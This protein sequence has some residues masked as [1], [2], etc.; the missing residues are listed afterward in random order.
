MIIIIFTLDSLIFWQSLAK[1]SN[2][3]TGVKINRPTILYQKHSTCIQYSGYDRLLA[4]G[5]YHLGAWPK[6]KGQHSSY[7]T[8]AAYPRKKSTDRCFAPNGSRRRSGSHSCEAEGPRGARR[9]AEGASTDRCF[10]PLRAEGACTYRCSL[11]SHLQRR[12]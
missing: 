3:R 8:G 9:P 6:A 5:R 11:R 1:Q 10:A 7:S 4:A 12:P 2:K